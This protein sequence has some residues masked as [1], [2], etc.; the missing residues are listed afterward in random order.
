VTAP[1]H[2][3]GRDDVVAEVALQLGFARRFAL[4]CGV[5]REHVEDFAQDVA[6]TALQRIQEGAF[7]PPEGKPLRDAVRAWLTGIVRFRAI[8]AMRK[9][10]FRAQV[11]VSGPSR[12]HPIDVDAHAVPSPEA[13]FDA[14]EELAA[15]ARLKLSPPQREVVRL[16]AL[17]YTAEEIGVRMKMSPNTVATHLKRA[18]M[19][20]ERAKG[21]RG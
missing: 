13:S 11:M 2:R 20:W 14:A 1:G 18:R 5:R 9:A 3:A 21:K 4:H 8:D 6:V 19:A 17:G 10:A 12:E 16:T 15:I 7:R